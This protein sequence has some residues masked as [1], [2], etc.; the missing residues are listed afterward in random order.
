M[1]RN[2]FCAKWGS[3][4][5]VVVCLLGMMLSSPVM[6]QTAGTGA[7]TGIVTDATGASVPNATVT[8]TNPA[9][10][11][12]RT[13]TTGGDGSYE[14]SLLTPGNYRVKF[15]ASGFETVEVPSVTVT[16]TETGTLNRVM[17]VGSQTQ[18][19]TI[20][21]DVETVNTSNA[22]VGA[23]MNSAAVVDLP[24]TTRN[25]QNLIGFSPGANAPVADAT[26]LG[27]NT[28][29]TAV[30]GATTAQNNFQLDG[31]GVNNILSFGAGQEGGFYGA[32]GIPSPDAIAEFKIQT[33]TYDAGY[34]RNPGANVN[35]VTKS[36][37]NDWHGTA[38]EFFRN[39]VLN[40]NTFF[41]NLSKKPEGALDQNQYGGV[42]GGPIIKNKFFIFGSY[43]K[44]WQKN[45]IASTGASTVLLPPIPTGDRGTCPVG[46]TVLTQ[47][48]TAAQTFVPAL[49]AAI[50]PANQVG[51]PSHPFDV[52]TLTG[53]LNVACDGSNINPVAV[54][55][56][57]LKLPNGN[58]YIPGSGIS[59]TKAYPVQTFSI[60]SYYK[61]YQ[62][63]LNTDY[64]I[65]SKNTFSE[66]F[67]MG[68]DPVTAP[69]A[70]A[71]ALPG[72]GYTSEYTNIETLVRLTTIVT[73]NLVNEV[74]GS[75]QRNV[76]NLNTQGQ[77]TAT[78]VGMTPNATADPVLPFIQIS[79]LFSFGTDG[80]DLYYQAVNQ[81]EI[82]DQLSWTHG[83]HTVRTGVEWEKDQANNFVTGLAVGQP[84]IGSFPDFLIGRAAGPVV[85]GGNG[86]A[87]SNIVGPDN[88]H[89]TNVVADGGNFGHYYRISDW[90]VFLQ[91]D[92]KIS[93]RLTVNLGLRWEYDGLPWDVNGA[94]S[95]IWPN[96][97]QAAGIPGTTVATG[98]LQGFVVPSNY[99]GFQPAGVVRNSIKQGTQNNAPLD[100]FAPR[101]GFAWQ[102]LS[103]KPGLVIRAGAGYFYDRSSFA[104][105]QVLYN[106]QPF[107]I[108]PSASPTTTLA[109][110]FFVPATVPAPPGIGFTPRFINFGLTP[111]ATSGGNSNVGNPSVAQKWY[112]PTQYEWNLDLQ[113][114][115]IRNWVFQLG[116]VGS[117]GLH[118]PSYHHVHLGF[119]LQRGAT[120]KR[121]Q[122]DP[123][124]LRWQSCRLYHREHHRE[125][126][127]P[128]A[129]PWYLV[130]SRSSRHLRRLQIQQ[131]TG[132]RA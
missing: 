32:Q 39:T 10:G 46:W 132:E 29:A 12:S 104:A 63:L 72:S 59:P 121:C 67:F 78:E 70:S 28:V 92:W 84:V 65:N 108:S 98:S 6:G 80:F 64:V 77:F 62:G 113:Y 124:R 116:Y 24:L 119:L 102:P 60:P 57:Q 85:S 56:L 73:P 122:P 100:N 25:Y 107:E 13:A 47:C 126:P 71:V 5:A 131:R 76:S 3:L 118:E 115:F 61:E 114:E 36:G 97:V 91:D 74:R 43:Q 18:E 11:Q 48:D 123:L 93:S 1:L 88:N 22:S 21:A 110:P 87:L 83:K 31:A 8:A 89:T 44:T 23:V 109:N 90:S 4:V 7:I 55:I 68:T 54:K 94:F 45:G 95:S 20:Q 52:T 79:N 53:G 117:R 69:F 42:L 128:C 17:T 58:Y 127:Q 37:T 34:G 2:G 38:F 111:N 26:A 112:T 41:F 129:E 96:L 16:V 99:F 27:K 49:G 9:T 40:A 15:E 50:C 14:I 86:T 66:R 19:V 103:S 105:Q 125:R 106:A 51:N 81:F 101:V 120:R 30:N 130:P 82:A 75:Y 35:V 33:S